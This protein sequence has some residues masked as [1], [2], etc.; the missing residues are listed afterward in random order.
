MKGSR[1]DVKNSNSLPEGFRVF[2]FDNQT[3]ETVPCPQNYT[4][5]LAGRRQF[6]FFKGDV[7]YDVDL[8]N[9]TCTCADFMARRRGVGSCKHLRLARVLESHTPTP[10]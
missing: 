2:F 4:I 9:T 6:L 8:E 5:E 1:G 3:S 7:V 10:C